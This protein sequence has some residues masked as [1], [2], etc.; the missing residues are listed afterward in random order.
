M[1]KYVVR[2]RL[3][4]WWLLGGVWS[5]SSVHVRCLRS[6]SD[7]YELSVRVYKIELALSKLPF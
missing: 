2:C 7:L 4:G 6:G 1:F 3:G 5:S